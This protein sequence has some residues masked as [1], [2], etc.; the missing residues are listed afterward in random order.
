VLRRALVERLSAGRPGGVTLVSAPPGSGKT[1][2][3]RSWVEHARLSQRVGWVSV[4]RDERDAQRFWLSVVTELRGAVGGE[5]LVETLMPTPDFEGVAVVRRLASDLEALDEPV[6]LVIDDLHELHS[7]EG[8]AQL[9]LLLTRLPRVLRVV[10]V[11]R[12]DP[13]LGLHRLRLAG[14]LTEVRAL[15]PPGDTRAARCVRDRTVGQ[16]PGHPPRADRGLGRGAPAGRDH[17]GGA[18]PT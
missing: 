9:E 2:L 16:R 6:V 1:A 14:E 3:L 10:L 4:E 15:H 18:S 5:S 17:T 7:A 8:L 13:H 11:T 12:R